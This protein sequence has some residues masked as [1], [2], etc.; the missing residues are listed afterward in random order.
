MN[1]GEK[2]KKK[3]SRRKKREERG[4]I[5][6]GRT[7]VSEVAS[8]LAMTLSRKQKQEERSKKQEGRREKF[9]YFKF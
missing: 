4:K 9:F 8:C 3:E 6:G 7:Q 1:G 2:G 5:A